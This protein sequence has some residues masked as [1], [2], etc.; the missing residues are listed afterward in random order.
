[1]P[2]TGKRP[3]TA[4]LALEFLQPAIHSGSDGAE[5]QSASPAA[6]PYFHTC[7][8]DPGCAYCASGSS[9]NAS[10]NDWSF[11]D[12]VYCISLRSR[13]D[14]AASA[15]RELHRVGLCRQCIFYRPV[16][17]SESAR[18]N[19]WHSHQ[20][21]ARHARASGV[22]R[23]LVLEDDVRFDASMD[24][25]VVQSIDE[26]IRSLPRDW[27]AFYLGHWP[28]WARRIDRHVLRT[29]SLCTHAYIASNLLLDWLCDA[30]YLDFKRRRTGSRWSLMG[31]GIDAAMSELPRMYAYYPMLATQ[32]GSVGDHAQT[33]ERRGLRRLYELKMR[34]RDHLLANHSGTWER[35]IVSLSWIVGAGLDTEADSGARDF[36][37]PN[38]PHPNV[39][40]APE[41][42]D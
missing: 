27:M 16:R 31:R 21:V 24:R 22:E 30:S 36:A 17:G 14:R 39:L 4:N 5:T 33:R 23:V 38:G 25:E 13:E 6:G 35:L 18:M 12:A 34:A 32:N 29:R 41:S 20:V 15:T 19:I 7:P 9:A 2:P 26:A 1:M 37:A 28:L 40:I 42:S 3:L 8:P 10:G 11:L